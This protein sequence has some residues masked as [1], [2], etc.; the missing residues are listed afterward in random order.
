[1]LIKLM[2]LHESHEKCVIFLHQCSAKNKVLVR[3]LT[4]ITMY[5]PSCVLVKK[6]YN[7]DILIYFYLD[8]MN[9]KSLL[10]TSRKPEKESFLNQ[11]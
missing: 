7:Y 10:S 5:K 8:L 1:M 3:L 9:I 4:L 11:W 6:K 2:Y